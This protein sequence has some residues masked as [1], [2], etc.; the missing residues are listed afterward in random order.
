MAS[1]TQEGDRVLKREEGRGESGDPE[2]QRETVRAGWREVIN[3]SSL[4]LQLCFC[5]G[6][7]QHWPQKLQG[8][9]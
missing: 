5:T 4:C 3:H 8:Y 1:A 9:F 7:G 2:D 6:T